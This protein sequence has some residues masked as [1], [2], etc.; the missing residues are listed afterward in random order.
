MASQQMAK[1]PR[2]DEDDSMFVEAP[3]HAIF[4]KKIRTDIP[5]GSM[6][7]VAN[8]STTTAPGQYNL[9]SNTDQNTNIT[10][11]VYNTS[12]TNT[13][14]VLQV[15]GNEV[16]FDV[17]TT[18]IGLGCH[19]NYALSGA[20]KADAAGNF[21]SNIYVS[22]STVE[23][24]EGTASVVPSLGFLAADVRKQRITRAV[25]KI[26]ATAWGSHSQVK[27]WQPAFLAN[28]TRMKP[29]K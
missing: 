20:P 27:Y 14:G 7:H 4:Q 8:M 15:K 3:N 26:N 13:S 23:M 18:V 25:P 1:R 28:D 10:L 21:A 12:G 24:P 9:T 11:N 29:F 19:A 17:E 22:A 5:G 6:R 2:S 16:H